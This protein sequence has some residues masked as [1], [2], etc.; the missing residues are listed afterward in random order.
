VQGRFHALLG[1]YEPVVSR[2]RTPI[3]R[4][5]VYAVRIGVNDRA[6]ASDICQKLRGAGGACIVK[7]NR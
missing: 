6:S 5:G 1:S 2:V 7:R 4:R 3:G